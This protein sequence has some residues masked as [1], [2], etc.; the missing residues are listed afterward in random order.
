M[1]DTIEVEGQRR[2]MCLC[3]S[4]NLQFI[5]SC[6]YFPYWQQLFVSENFYGAKNFIK[7]IHNST[8]LKLKMFRFLHLHFY[9][10]FIAF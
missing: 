2:N 6:D 10:F 8:S 5:S 7:Y 9:F 3:E 1:T 4:L